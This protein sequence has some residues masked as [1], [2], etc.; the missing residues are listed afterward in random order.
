VRGLINQSI[1]LSHHET[2]L[3]LDLIRGRA[4]AK[5]NETM[6][7]YIKKKLFKRNE[8]HVRVKSGDG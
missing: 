5:A 7:P 4:P 2:L 3:W 1:K 8:I 6:N